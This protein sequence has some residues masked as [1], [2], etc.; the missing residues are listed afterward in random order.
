MNEETSAAEQQNQGAERTEVSEAGDNKNN[1]PVSYETHRRLL[2]QKKELAARLQQASAELEEVRSGMQAREQKEL[3]EQNRFKELYEKVRQD[4]ENLQKAISERDAQMQKAIKLDAFQKSLGD[5]KI[6]RKYA[7]FI[8]TDNIIFDP[9]TGNVDELSAQK[10][11]ERILAE[12]PE[13][14]RVGQTKAMPTQAPAGVS[15][16]AKM[17][18]QDRLELLAKHLETK[19]RG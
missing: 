11:V 15:S 17:S 10:E 5:K 2:D 13:I 1:S 9:E 4:N 19:R 3:E 12:F 18:M 14:V 16:H 6:D 7:G 8:N